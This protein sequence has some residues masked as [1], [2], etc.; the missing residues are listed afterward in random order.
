MAEPGPRERA[1]D[2]VE[3]QEVVERPGASAQVWACAEDVRQEGGRIA[4]TAA[5]RVPPGAGGG[6]LAGL[7]AP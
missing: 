4:D 7:V 5:E 6:S 2:V 3:R 1:V